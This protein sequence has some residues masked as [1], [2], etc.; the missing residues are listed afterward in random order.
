MG[1]D[2]RRSWLAAH[3]RGAERVVTHALGQG[4]SDDPRSPWARRT[5]HGIGRHV[6]QA[7]SG[8][9]GSTETSTPDGCVR[10]RMMRCVAAR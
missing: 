5:T 7:P 2:S 3:I 8:S 6:G 1:A 9:A 4:S 10:Q